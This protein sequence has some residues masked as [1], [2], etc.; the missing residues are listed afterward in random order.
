MSAKFLSLVTVFCLIALP[1]QSETLMASPYPASVSCETGLPGCFLSKDSHD[2]VAAFYERDRGPATTWKNDPDLDRYSFYEYMD[3][4][5]VHQYDPIGSAIGVRIYSQRVPT[6][7]GEP[8]TSLPVVGEVFGKLKLLTVQD[9][10]S[11]EEYN[12]LVRKYRHLASWYYPMEKDTATSDRPVPKDKVI[13]A[14][15]EKGPQEQETAED[16]E[17][18]AMKA[19]QLMLQGRQREA[20]AL[21]QHAGESAQGIHEKGLGPEGIKK[22]EGCLEELQANGYPTR[23]EIAV[24]PSK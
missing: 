2:Q 4:H 24:N 8:E 3:V 19:Q 21:L 22:W 12:A 6:D 10:M 15:C 11:M 7:G 23:I 18:M 17:A 14:R 13:L 5:T 1:A 9:S 20:L 16:M